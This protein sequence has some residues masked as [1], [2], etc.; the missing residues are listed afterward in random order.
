MQRVREDLSVA[1]KSA[2]VV[3]SKG[4]A[5]AVLLTATNKKS[6]DHGAAAQLKVEI[7]TRFYFDCA[8][9]MSS[10]AVPCGSI[11]AGADSKSLIASPIGQPAVHL[12][13]IG[14]TVALS[15]D[16]TGLTLTMDPLS[17]SCC[18]VASY[19]TNVASSPGLP[20]TVTQ[21]KQLVINAE[22]A[23]EAELEAQYL[24]PPDPTTHV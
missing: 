3:G 15:S 14:G 9:R 7:A 17:S 1:V 13:A 16:G 2:H 10:G 4:D 11:R 20:R 18:L 5:T 6:S 23:L 8:P 24:I 19:S 22:T 12:Q 21:C